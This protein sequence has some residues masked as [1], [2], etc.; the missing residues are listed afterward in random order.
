MNTS[1]SFSSV[2]HLYSHVFFADRLS[3]INLSGSAYLYLS[4]YLSSVDEEEKP[5][6]GRIDRFLSYGNPVLS[7][8][9][10]LFLLL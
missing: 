1:F 2:A 9:L 4:I 10:F 5:F 8:L 6:L 7:L 3:S